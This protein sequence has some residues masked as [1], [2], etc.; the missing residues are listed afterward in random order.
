MQQ[1]SSSAGLSVDAVLFDLDGTLVD[2]FSLIAESFTYAVRKVLA[3]DPTPEELRREWG[4]PLRTRAAAVAPG[5]VDELV[6]AYEKY[7]DRLQKD[8]LR[9][10]PG[11]RGMLLALR[12]SGLRLGVV[13]SKR[14]ERTL[15]TLRAVALHSL[16]DCIVTDDDVP[17]PKPSPDPIHRAL[18][19]LATLPPRALM[20]GDAPFDLMAARAAGVRTVAAMWGT[21]DPEKLLALQPDYVA[22]EPSD[23]VAIVLG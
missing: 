13:T 7:Y 19:Q 23:V 16:F 3:R 20:V 4:A 21:R 12:R 2:S 22:T 10:F 18:E 1:S 5:H 8:A 15:T 6:A 11:V 14:R 9:P 17:R